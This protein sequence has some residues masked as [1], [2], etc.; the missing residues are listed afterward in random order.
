MANWR[1]ITVAVVKTK[2][3]S[4]IECFDPDD[5]DEDAKE[6]DQNNRIMT[7]QRNQKTRTVNRAYAN[8]TG[9]VFS[10]LWDGKVRMGLQASK[11]SQDFWGGDTI[12]KQ[13]KRKDRGETSRVTKRVA[14]GVYRPRKPWL[15][16]ALE[17]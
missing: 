3:A 2:F 9:T 8:Q 10:N 16:E 14:M 4:H 12:F 13:E 17:A 1:Q 6:I 15:A 5:D 7:Q 11:L